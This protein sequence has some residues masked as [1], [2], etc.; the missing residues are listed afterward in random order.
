MSFYIAT[1]GQDGAIILYQ[2][3]NVSLTN[4]SNN[5]N[6]DTLHIVNFV[7]NPYLLIDDC[8]CSNS[9]FSKNFQNNDQ[10]WHLYKES[11]L[12][13]HGDSMVTDLRWFVIN[14]DLKLV[15]TD[16]DRNI[17]LWS[18][19]KITTNEQIWVDNV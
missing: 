14:R 4:E 5:N 12:N 10:E 6:L 13:G 17:I 11:V 7:W 1:T 19:D 9:N 2:L 18:N 8:D 15:S 16:E 3:R